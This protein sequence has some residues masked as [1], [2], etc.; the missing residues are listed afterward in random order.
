MNSQIKYF[1][2]GI[3]EYEEA[4]KKQEILFLDTI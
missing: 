4:L 3:I 1:D 2:W